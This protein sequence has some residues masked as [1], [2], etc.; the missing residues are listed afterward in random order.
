MNVADDVERTLLVFL[1]GP[2]T[3]PRDRRRVDLLNALEGP[4]VAKSFALEPAQ[5]APKL[6][7]LLPDDVGTEGAVGPRAVA[8]LRD[9]LRYV[10]HDRN[11]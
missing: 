1:V 5:R 8:L 4:D 9:A 6:L 2:E 11:W 10:E 7:G 3:L